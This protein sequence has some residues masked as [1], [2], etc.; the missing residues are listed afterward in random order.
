MQPFG[1]CVRCH[2]PCDSE[3]KDEHN[4]KYGKHFNRSRSSKKIGH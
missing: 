4:G 1:K 2:A 3:H